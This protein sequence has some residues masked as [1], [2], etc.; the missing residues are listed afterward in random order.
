MN[1]FSR[2]DW[3]IFLPALF[4]SVLGSLVLSSVAPSSFPKQ[5]VYLALALFSFLLFSKVDLRVL[6]GFA[7]WLYV[8][9]ILLLLATMLFGVIARGAARWIVIG[10]FNLQPSEITKPFFLIFFAWLVSGIYGPKKFLATAVFALLAFFLILDQPDLG[11]GLVILAGFLGVIF[12]G[13]I[14]IVH[15]LLGLFVVAFF[16]PLGWHFLADYQKQRII[17]FLSPHT[18]PL[19]AGYNALQAV[20]AVGSGEFAGRGL[21]GGTQSQL[22]FL[23]ERQSDFIFSAFAEE[24]GFL[25]AGMLII[26][27]TV[28]FWRIIMV[29]KDTDDIFSRSFLGG[30][31]LVLFSQTVINIGMNLGVLPITGIPL[32]FVSA[33]GSSL[34]SMAALLGMISS[35]SSDLAKKDSL[36]IIR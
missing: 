17:S 5:F 32:P 10:P 34:V 2:V 24:L 3:R 16:S 8:G 28:L 36:G 19:G 4:L 21:G 22:A 15:L 26:A 14:P 6:H 18:D 33:G 23:P 30:A 35:I 20:I 31:F 25:G 29:L 12:M 13:R 9:S 27:F 11:S 1:L 7:P